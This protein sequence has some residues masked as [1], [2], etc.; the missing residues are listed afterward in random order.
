MRCGQ[1]SDSN[2][3]NID[4]ENVAVSFVVLFVVVVALLLL[5]WLLAFDDPLLLWLA[6]ARVVVVFDS[7]VGVE[8]Q[9]SSARRQL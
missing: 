4:T 5:S 9:C 3:T 8:T 6:V 2:G 1:T 7:V